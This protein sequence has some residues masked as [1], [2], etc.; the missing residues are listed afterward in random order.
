MYKYSES[1][2]ENTA[3]SLNLVPG[4]RKEIKEPDFL[5]LTRVTHFGSHNFAESRFGRLVST[6][7]LADCRA[8]EVV[9][10]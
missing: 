4:L 9:S 10:I 8:Y 1:I 7:D 5:Y 2:K 3:H 6:L